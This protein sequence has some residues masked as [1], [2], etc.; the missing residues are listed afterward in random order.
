MDKKIESIREDARDV[1]N[2]QG[3][4]TRLTR[5]AL[6]N[7][8][9]LTTTAS[10]NHLLRG[11]APSIVEVAAKRV[12]RI[13]VAA[14]LS[15]SGLGHINPRTQ[16][17]TERA[18]LPTGFGGAGLGSAALARDA[19]YISS[20]AATAKV[21]S[22]LVTQETKFLPSLPM[23][24][25]LHRAL[26]RVK[27]KCRQSFN[28]K[29]E[30]EKAVMELTTE[31]ILA[32]DFKQPTHLQGT[33]TTMLA[34]AQRDDIAAQ[35]KGAGRDAELRSFLSC[36]GSK[37]GNFL[38]AGEKTPGTTMD[39]MQFTIAYSLRLGV[40]AFADILPGHKCRLCGKAIGTSATHGALCTREGTGMVTRNERHY[41][42]NAEIARI[43]KLLD[44]STRIRFEPSIVRH[45]HKQPKNWKQDG[46]R[47]GDLHVRTATMNYIIDTSVGL[48]AA[49][50]APAAA[51]TK[52][53]VVAQKLARDKVVQ[54]V[55]TYRDFKEHEIV[56]ACAEGEG[57]L[58][59]GFQKFLQQ[60]I[61]DGW[62]INPTRPKSVVAAEVYARLSTALQRGN[63]DGVINWRYAECGEAIHDAD[64]DPIR[65]AL[66]S[67][68]IDLRTC[69][70]DLRSRRGIAAGGVAVAGGE[71][72]EGALA[73]AG[74]ELAELGAVA[75][76]MAVLAEAVA[77]VRDDGPSNAAALGVGND[78]AMEGTVPVGFQPTGVA[79][80]GS[81]QY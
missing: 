20:F 31:G 45:F 34:R 43:L 74:G 69:D 15:T 30:D 66:N 18:G 46:W 37:A 11:V 48:A 13:A 65:A 25:E 33:I 44:P 19:A 4:H 47:R 26:Q 8:V 22:S 53:G 16:H 55:S 71:A 3:K 75:A 42:L 27:A 23:M 54:Y 72:A 61:D 51:N 59:L 2:V 68:A 63:A 56:P 57:A 79:R 35:L 78:E 24:Q 9:R 6:T 81:A 5:K 73:E 49:A 67:P 28:T 29:S 52:A 32:E 70:M 40:E 76:A 50:S 7:V 10:F 17:V 62:F 60:R 38:V 1:V 36:G 64:S 21:V 58:D 12:D 77:G 41:A 39:D 80:Q 14:A